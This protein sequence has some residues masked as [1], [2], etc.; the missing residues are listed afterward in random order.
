MVL[1]EVI[2]R[3]KPHIRFAETE[4]TD[5]VWAPDVKRELEGLL[6]RLKSRVND[7]CVN[8]SVTGE[9]SSG[10]SSV[11]NA[12]LGM[13]LLATDEM[14]DT[15]LVPAVL[16]YSEQPVFVTVDMKGNQTRESMGVDDI[17]RRLSGRAIEQQPGESDENFT[18]RMFRMRAEAD[19]EASKIRQFNIG[20]PSELLKRGFRIIDTPGLN[21][22]NRRCAEVTR[23]LLTRTDASIIVGNATGGGIKEVLREDLKDLLN[24]KLMNSAV[25]FTH[26]DCSN[27]REKLATYLQG[28]TAAYFGMK[29]DQLPVLMMVPPTVAAARRGERF[30]DDHEEMLAIT[31]HSIERIASYAADRRLRI[32]FSELMQLTNALFNRMQQ[33]IYTLGSQGRQNLEQLERSRTAP[34]DN[35]VSAT[36]PTMLSRMEM[37]LRIKRNNLDGRLTGRINDTR[38]MIRETMRN[39]NSVGSLNLFVKDTVPGRLDELN[40]QMAETAETTHSQS[41][42]VVT[43]YLSNFENGL[44]AECRRL[45]IVPVPVGISRK[46]LEVES[47]QLEETVGSARN[48]ASAELKRQDNAV[49]AAVIGGIIGSIFAPGIGTAIG[50]AIGAWFGADGKAANVKNAFEKVH[51]ELDRKVLTEFNAYRNRLVKSHETWQT[52]TMEMVRQNLNGYVKRYKREVDRMIADEEKKRAQV[53]A[54]ILGYEKRL[55]KITKQRQEIDKIWRTR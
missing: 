35:Y 31:L 40:K 32:I 30:G 55:E 41:V 54:Q 22:T 36:V 23:D 29:P 24:R 10:K 18:R 14:P 9:F 19:E 7:K 1:Q 50:A 38:D 51:P 17:R 43:R 20:I 16:F 3:L 21:S 34:I 26:F 52:E 12:L 44:R 25:V 11:I 46:S 48:L 2:D 49:G 13:E 5:N 27:R 28:T 6:E 37:D 8:I 53:R 4:I 45:K 33:S 39:Q 47:T 15:T 42:D